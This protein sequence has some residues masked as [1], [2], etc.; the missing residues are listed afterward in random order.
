[1]L[2]FDKDMSAE[3]RQY[4][5]DA[6]DHARRGAPPSEP[7]NAADAKTMARSMRAED[8]LADTG[9][10]VRRD[11]M[12]YPRGVSLNLG[13]HHRATLS[14]NSDGGWHVRTHPADYGSTA[15]HIHHDLDVRDEDLPG[16]LRK[17]YDSPQVRGALAAQQGEDETYRAGHHEAAIESGGGAEY[18]GDR[19]RPEGEERWDFTQGPR[20]DAECPSCGQRADESGAEQ[21]HLNIGREHPVPSP[22][23][24]CGHCDEV[25]STYKSGHQARIDRELA[26]LAWKNHVRGRDEGDALFSH[27][28]KNPTHPLLLWG[29]E[30]KLPHDMHRQEQQ[31]TGP[32]GIPLPQG[33]DMGRQVRE[34]RLH[35]ILSDPDA[36]APVDPRNL[37]K[38]FGEI[39]RLYPGSGEHPGEQAHPGAHLSSREPVVAHFDEGGP[40]GASRNHW[41]MTE[42]EMRLH[43]RDKH[44][45]ADPAGDP[46]LAHWG[47]H[48]GDVQRHVHPDLEQEFVR[49]ANPSIPQ[50]DAFISAPH[51]GPIDPVFGALQPG[52]DAASAREERG[53]RWWNYQQQYSTDLHR[54]IH[55]ALPGDL[56]TYVHDESVPRE[57]R[58]RALQQ[59]FADSGE[60]LGMHWTPHVNIAH[61]AIGNAADAGHGLSDGRLY[62]PEG[63]DAT[64]DIMFHVR[65]PGERNRLPAREHDDHDIGWSYSRDE[66]EFPL[67]PGSPLR[68]S[69]ISWKRHEAEY[70][71][72]PYEHADFPR[73]IRHVPS[74]AVVATR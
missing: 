38:E 61:R 74:L 32:G 40:E 59:H 49:A 66:D 65:K 54:G 26:N 64:T 23:A 13:E 15:E 69:G 10:D 29:D 57:D 24:R 68:L 47:E 28:T 43:L 14:P 27:I 37:H 20:P 48:S 11:V 4:F 8:A 17:Y 71:N 31:F 34:H 41:D 72:E 67:R 22:L 16:E 7:I 58:A 56:H 73:A 63:P 44:E 2:N 6:I 45:I 30:S 70:P 36:S 19:E 18:G 51:S 46:A 53:D 5:Q 62:H 9:W 50:G 60:G 42:A 25:F 12:R 52:P 55:V 3:D 33:S 21:L 1:M 35:R 39:P